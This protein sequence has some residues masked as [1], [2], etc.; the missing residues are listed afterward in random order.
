M[1][2]LSLPILT[3][4]PTNEIPNELFQEKRSKIYQLEKAT[5]DPAIITSFDIKH[6]ST[7]NNTPSGV[8]YTFEHPERYNYMNCTAFYKEGELIGIGKHT[9]SPVFLSFACRTH[10]GKYTLI[11]GC[12]CSLPEDI[13]HDLKYSR[14]SRKKHS[15]H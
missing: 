4:V 2:K 9:G 13:K 11:P 5:E 6:S 10:N 7:C 15:P 1:G 12:V 8:H 3:I 14:G